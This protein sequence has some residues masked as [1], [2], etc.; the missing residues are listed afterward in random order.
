MGARQRA[1]ERREVTMEATVRELSAASPAAIRNTEPA[2]GKP[3]P[4][5]A[6]VGPGEVRLVVERV[7]KAQ[8]KWAALGFAERRRR[9]S[10]F[11]NLVLDRSQ[12]LAAVISRE[13]GKPPFE[14]LLHDIAPLVNLTAFYARG[15][16]RALRDRRVPIRMFPHKRSYLRY[17]PR[18][19]I[20]I[21][22]AWNFP[23][24]VPMGE[25]VTALAA[26]NG[27]VVKPSEFTPLSALEGKKLLDE[28]GIDPELVA[29]LPGFGPTGAA[30]IDAG[31]DMMVFVG[32]LAT[33][34]KVAA[35]CGERLIPCVLELG[36]K[37]PAIVLQDANLEAAARSVVF[38]AFANSGQVCASVERVYVDR[39]VAEPFTL[40]VVELTKKLRQGGGGEVDVGAMTTP[41]QLETVR[42]HVDQA[43]AAGAKALTGAEVRPGPGRFYAPTVLTGVSH[44]MAVI[45]EETFGPVLPIIPFD[46]EEEAIKLANDSDYGLSAYV[47]SKSTRHAEQVA[48]R[49]A[50][51]TVIVNDVLYTHGVPELPWGGVKCSGVGRTHGEEALREMCWVRH[52]NVERFSLP[53]PWLFPYREAVLRRL[54]KLL[55]TVMRLFN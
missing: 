16:K 13:T 48:N 49:L 7:R 40:R 37:D 55:R 11:K 23:F 22:S 28:A 9:L 8:A 33:G 46:D 32:S 4:A 31:V 27:A 25:V 34:R 5:V 2:T 20:G 30:L 51:G 54:E 24:S 3:L 45:R 1:D 17:E 52:V 14:G 29:V 42:R 44:E 36:G 39:A 18:G 38:G 19:V 41:A 10:A 50:A 15:A 53:K 47:F 6:A 35:S 12:E 43:L 26:G 21:I